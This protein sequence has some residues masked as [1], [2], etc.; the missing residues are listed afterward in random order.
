VSRSPIRRVNWAGAQR[1]L[2]SDRPARR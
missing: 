1:R 2:L